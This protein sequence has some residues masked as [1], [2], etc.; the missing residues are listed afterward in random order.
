M[1]TVSAKPGHCNGINVNGIHAQG[2][3]GT[4]HTGDEENHDI[5]WKMYLFIFNNCSKQLF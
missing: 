5:L 1:K 2:K 4:F 3:S